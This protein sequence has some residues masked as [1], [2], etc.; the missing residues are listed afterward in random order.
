MRVDPF[1]RRDFALE[2]DRLVRVEFGRKRV[3]R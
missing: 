3:M 1:H 2:G